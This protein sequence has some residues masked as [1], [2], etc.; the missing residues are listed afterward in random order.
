[1]FRIWISLAALIYLLG[2]IWAWPLLVRAYPK[3]FPHLYAKR[4]VDWPFV[5]VFAAMW[6]L[7]FAFGMLAA[8][9]QRFPAANKDLSND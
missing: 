1:M 2:V 3:H 9:K 7:S 8:P 4:G 5:S 6:P